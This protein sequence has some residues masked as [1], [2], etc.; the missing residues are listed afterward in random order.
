MRKPVT[1]G[2]PGHGLV[3]CSLIE[4]RQWGAIDD[5]FDERCIHAAPHNMTLKRRDFIRRNDRHVSDFTRKLAVAADFAIA[6]RAA[7][8]L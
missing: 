8:H 3:E 6:S 5:F 1:R 4:R 7:P 2:R